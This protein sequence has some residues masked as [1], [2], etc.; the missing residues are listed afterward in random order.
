[1]ETDVTT[2]FINT[3]RR[4][5]TAEYLP[6]IENCLARLS[7]EDVWW[8]GVETS[9]SV[10]NLVLHLNGN[11]RQWIIGGVGEREFG[12]DRQKEVD[13]RELIPKD[14]L[15]AQLKATVHEADEVIAHLNE[16]DLQVRRE[17]QGRAMS[18]LEAVFHV[19]EHFAQ[20]TGQIIM[21]TKMRTGE[22]LKLYVPRQTIN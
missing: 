18:K 16:K 11:V 10:G 14:E 21:L 4:Y 17:I 6:K 12:R 22:D 3:S 7:V 8:R 20:H 5:L 15:L 2:D 1:M 19:V 9:N 13:A